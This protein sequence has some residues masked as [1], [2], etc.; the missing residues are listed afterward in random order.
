MKTRLRRKG[1]VPAAK[2]VKARFT[3][4]ADP[5]F[6]LIRRS[7][8][9]VVPADQVIRGG[10]GAS[11]Q[12]GC[13]GAGAPI[14]FRPKAAG[15]TDTAVANFR[16]LLKRF[17]RRYPGYCLGYGGDRHAIGGHVH[18]GI[19]GFVFSDEQM[20]DMT[21]LIDDFVGQY[22]LPLSGAARGHYREL[23]AWRRQPWGMEYRVPPAGAWA[24]PRLTKLMLKIIKNLCFAYINRPSMKYEIPHPTPRDYRA[25]A[26]LP[27]NEHDE[28]KAEIA[29]LRDE[30][31]TEKDLLAKWE[32]TPQT[33]QVRP[34]SPSPQSAEVPVVV[35]F[36]DEWS[37]AARVAMVDA[38]NSIIPSSFRGAA[39]RQVRFFL[40][41]LRASRGMVATVRVSGTQAFFTEVEGEMRRG[42]QPDGQW[43]VGL[44]H[45][46]RSGSPT[47]EA[48]REV[49]RAIAWQMTECGYLQR[50]EVV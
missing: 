50:S 3:V 22:I 11:V 20:R 21:K 25:H 28:F 37:G 14:E 32:I 40:Y 6:E 8:G 47:P 9:R 45:A 7:D 17:A 10:T 49:A 26:N 13:D 5:E 48:A 35:E 31:P 24:T 18:I 15:H 33:A 30:A 36:A 1:P 27:Y 23:G 4:G 41:G 46:F 16:R 38:F 44:P 2:I 42:W 12:I 43:A 29:R 19:D 39:G 34:A